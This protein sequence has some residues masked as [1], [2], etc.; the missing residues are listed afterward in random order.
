MLGG[1]DS[2]NA[3][4]EH[5]ILHVCLQPSIQGKVQAEIDEVIGATREPCYEDRK[6]M[7]YTLAVLYE[8]LRFATPVPATS[9]C[10][11]RDVEFQGSTVI[12]KV[13]F[14]NAFKHSAYR[15][16]PTASA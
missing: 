12:P 15:V 3:A 10:P 1:L 16:P 13:Y 8:T 5:A 14:L 11:L 7:P 9:R 4:L 2:T 6:R